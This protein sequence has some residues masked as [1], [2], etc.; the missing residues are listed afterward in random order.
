M[1]HA[2]NASNIDEEL[3]E[4]EIR[5]LIQ[6]DNFGDNYDLEPKIGLLSD[7]EI[8]KYADKSKTA[9]KI[10]LKRG[11]STSLDKHRIHDTDLFL[12][13][14][15]L[16]GIGSTIGGTFGGIATKSI[17]GGLIV[18]LF[19]IGIPTIYTIHVLY[20]KDYAEVKAKTKIEKES[21]LAEEDNLNSQPNNKLNNIDFSKI[22]SPFKNYGEQINELE[23]LYQIKEKIARNLIE[24]SFTPP[25]ITYDR[26]MGV[27]DSCNT[28]FYKQVESALNIIDVGTE[29]SIKA[30][31]ELKKRLNTL[32]S[33]IKK[34]DE[35]TNEMIVNSSNSDEESY[36]EEVKD[37]MDEMKKLAESVKEYK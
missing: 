33:L 22:T 3:R 24:K 20:L 13:W 16:G 36:H 17:V 27:M 26:F 23:E 30:E 18:L 35:L 9:S 34:I 31:L 10:R 6:I 14:T 28:L 2:E 37:L 32:K 25:Q 11:I 8:L 12:I 7:D 19:T 21:I 1:N 4:Q 15:F 5:R 29:H